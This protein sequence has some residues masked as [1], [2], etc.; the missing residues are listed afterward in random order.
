MSVQWL[1]GLNVTALATAADEGTD[2]AFAN[3]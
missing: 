3:E 2:H 1:N